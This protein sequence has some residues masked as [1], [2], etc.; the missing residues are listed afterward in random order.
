MTEIA[1]GKP[2]IIRATGADPDDVHISKG[3]AEQVIWKS[4]IGAVWVVSPRGGSPFSKEEFEV[5]A[6]GAEPSGQPV[7]EPGPDGY[8]YDVK[9]AEGVLFDPRVFID[10]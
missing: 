4:E 3:R 6:N 7:V 9:D 2:V 1:N 8:K 10:R 5:P